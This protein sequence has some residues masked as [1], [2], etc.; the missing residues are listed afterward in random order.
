MTKEYSVSIKF[1]VRFKEVIH[2]QYHKSALQQTFVV[3]VDSLKDVA[4]V[5]MI[6]NIEKMSEKVGSSRDV[7]SATKYNDLATLTQRGE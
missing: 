7:C 2:V 6:C 3:K 4:M 1:K 5:A